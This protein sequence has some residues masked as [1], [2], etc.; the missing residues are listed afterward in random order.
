M[1]V[2]ELLNKQSYSTE[3]TD[4]Q[5]AA[6]SQVSLSVNCLSSSQTWCCV[7]RL[8]L[9]TK[10]ISEISRRYFF[11]DRSFNFKSEQLF[12]S[13]M[14]PNHYQDSIQNYFKSIFISHNKLNIRSELLGKNHNTIR[15]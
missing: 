4:R 1:V 6:V 8:A 13:G 5:P 15:I 3:S 14:L 9:N 10:N 11:S 12:C 2:L 7:G